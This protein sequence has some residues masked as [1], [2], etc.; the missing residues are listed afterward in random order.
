MKEIECKEKELAVQ[1]K[2]KELELKGTTAIDT[3]A[4]EK[5]DGPSFDVSKH[6][7]FMPTFSENKVDKYFLHFEKVECSLKWLRDSWMLLLQSTL[8]GK[9]RE[10][11]SALSIE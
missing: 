2:L 7:R 4:T 10:T 8:V 9:A 5:P 6:I 11:Y 1:L 3:R